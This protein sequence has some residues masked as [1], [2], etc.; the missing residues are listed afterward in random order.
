MLF[1]AVVQFVYLHNITQEKKN[2][3]KN[4][5]SNFIYFQTKNLI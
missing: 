3:F 1:L 4:K 5:I 2:I